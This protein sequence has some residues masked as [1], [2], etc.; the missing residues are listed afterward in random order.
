MLKIVNNSSNSAETVFQDK[1]FFQIELNSK[2]TYNS[3]L[4]SVLMDNNIQIYSYEHPTIT[5]PWFNLGEKI[6]LSALSNSDPKNNANITLKIDNLLSNI[7]KHYHHTIFV[8]GS[9]RPD[10]KVGAAVFCTSIP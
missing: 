9:V 1:K 6:D 8:D 2:S 4:K 10:N 3:D 7:S 5:P